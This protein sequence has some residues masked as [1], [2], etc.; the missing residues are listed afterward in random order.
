M[1]STHEF[2]MVI[3]GR[4][5]EHLGSMMY[6]HR[7][8]SIAELVANCWDAGAK[9]V[10]ITVPT[11]EDYSQAKSEIVI[12]DSGEGMNAD[13]IQ[14]CYMVVGR[15]RR[16]EQIEENSLDRKIMGRK[17][18]GKLAGFGLAEHV[19]VTTW[20][21][22]GSAIRFNMP[23][24]ELKKTKAGSTDIIRF[25][26]KEVN[27]DKEWPSSGSIVKLSL[28][29]H[30]T[31]L[32][33]KSLKETLARR[34]ARTVH[35]EM[36]IFVNMEPLGEPQLD[37]IHSHPEEGKFD[38]ATLK[39]GQKVKFRYQY[40][41][42]PIKSKEMR[43][44]TIQANGRTAQAPPFFFNVETTASSQHSTRYIAGEIVA[45]YIDEWDEDQKD[46]ISTDRQE[47]DWE[48]A[49]LAELRE[50][51]EELT[52]KLLR[53]CAEKHGKELENWVLTDLDFRPR[54][55]RLEP[56]SQRE[57]GNFLKTLG[58]K[59]SDGEERTRS[60][61]DSLIR[62]YEFRVFHDVIDDIQ[63]VGDDPEKLEEILGRLRD[64]K[65]LESRAI[66]EIVQGRLSIVKKLEGMLNNNAPETASKNTYDNLHDLLAEY[67]WLFDPEWQVFTEEK[68]ISKQLKDWGAKDCP[69]DIGERRVDFLAFGKDGELIVIEIKRPGHGVTLKEIQRIE[70]YQERLRVAHPNSRRVLVYGGKLDVSPERAETYRNESGKPGAL[71]LIEW[72]QMF[73]RANRYYAHYEAV[74]KGD[75]QDQK[76]AAK[77]NE[78]I[79]TQQVLETTSH[80]SKKDRKR[81]L[82][83]ADP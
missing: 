83:N 17:G 52:R 25:P 76:F 78:V 50:W 58:Q 16:Q 29:R 10:W 7:S 1:S 41:K 44:F 62:A 36:K 63:K 77:A 11:E 47:L 31:P 54:L 12:M 43:G 81:G 18:I 49:E 65:V 51:G 30:S 33:V 42:T 61:A 60:L 35:G 40:S 70:E 24:E 22:G 46:C 32:D 9:E 8:P 48:K 56:A 80:R 15:N 45:D 14:K 79:R 34:F 74:L 55:A 53:D 82:G 73:A 20:K 2:E 67:P 69:E 27:K 13:S 23:L 57:I 3:L 75:V 39:N 37:I 5:I 21:K 72:H 4:I 38:D 71:E 26:W 59:N 68:S 19:S 28:L 66:L 6:K 64:W